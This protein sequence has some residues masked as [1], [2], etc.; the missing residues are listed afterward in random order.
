[1]EDEEKH[2]TRNSQIR[3]VFPSSEFDSIDVD[4][5]QRHKIHFT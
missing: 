2:F 5:Q 4:S 3:R 1:M